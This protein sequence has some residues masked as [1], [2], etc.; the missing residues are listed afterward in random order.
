MWKSRYNGCLMLNVVKEI[1]LS[2]Y[3]V[4]KKLTKINF[5]SIWLKNEKKKGS[6]HTWFC[7]FCIEFIISFLFSFPVQGLSW[8]IEFYIRL[9]NEEYNV[10]YTGIY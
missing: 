2:I 10:P 3:L 5:F 6:Q 4:K 9:M 7:T 1:L 8:G